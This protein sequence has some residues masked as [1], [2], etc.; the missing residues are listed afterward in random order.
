MNGNDVE[1]RLHDYYTE[2]TP[3]DSTRAV[4]G[5]GRVIADARAH[6]RLGP[7]PLIGQSWLRGFAAAAGAAV[8]IGVLAVA[9]LPLWNGPAAA[10]GAS[11]SG[12]PSP[13]TSPSESVAIASPTGSVAPSTS[14]TL[15]IN[16]PPVAARW[17]KDGSMPHSHAGTHVL[18]VGGGKVLVVGDDNLFAPG[19][20]YATQAEIWDP[21]TDKWSAT[22]GLDA[23]RD[24]FGAVALVDGKAIVFGGLDDNTTSYSSARIYDPSTGSWTATGSLLQ[25]RTSPA[26]TRLADGRVLAIGGEDFDGVH[27]TYL[28]TAEIFNPATGRW[29]AT[30][31]LHAPRSEG[32]AVTLADGRVLVVGGM[33]SDSTSAVNGEVYDPATGQW[34]VTG[35]LAAIRTE[36][37]LAALP[38]GSALVAGGLTTASAERLDPASLTWK[39]AGKMKSAVGSRI[40]IVLANGKVL[41]AGGRGG[42]TK[43]AISAAEIYD[44]VAGTWTAT[45]SMPMTLER[46]GAVLLNNGSVLIAGGDG[47][48]VGQASTPWYPVARQ[49]SIV[50]YPAT[51]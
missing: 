26:Y 9:L 32:Q 20:P 27:S 40:A 17:V 36:S 16:A 37:S 8:V 6:R 13:A 22:A 29:T 50:Y 18:L 5:V 38:D 44:P 48:F 43:P 23:P 34:T 33:N 24:S 7:A 46:A 12:S 4:A 31:S 41:F 51:K 19:P 49:Q 45:A 30:G 42:G 21:S 10:P 47:G 3:R 28:A 35:N 2:F 39:S 11:G 14:P 1:Q 15:G 25:P